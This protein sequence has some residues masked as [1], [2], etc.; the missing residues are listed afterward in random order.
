M[1]TRSF[2]AGVAFIAAFIAFSAPALAD[3][4]PFAPRF[5][6]NETGNIAMAANSL[7]TCTTDTDC[8]AARNGPS[9]NTTANDELNNNN[10]T[11][12]YI[13]VDSDSSTFS[14]SSANLN[15]PNGSSVLWAGLYW[16]GDWS[17][18]GGTAP[19]NVN[20]RNKMKLKL[21]GAGSYTNVTAS[22]VDESALNIGR[23]QAFADVT[24]LVTSGGAGSYFGANVQAG[25]SSDHYAGW[26]MVVAYKDTTQPARN[27]TV[28][29][30]LKTIRPSDPPTTIT[31]SGFLTPPS[32]AVNSNVGFITW[33]GDLG[34]VGDTAS[35]NGTTLSD[36]TNPATNFFNGTIESNTRN[37]SYVNNFGFDADI[38]QTTNVLPNSSTS[39]T[40]RLTT[41]GDQYLPGALFFAT[42][43]Y[44]PSIAQSKTVTDLNGGETLPGDVLEYTVTNTNSNASGTDAAT[45]F[46][47]RD[48][49]P[50]DT[51]YVPGSLK[52]DGAA[53]TD[54]A[55]DDTANYD[56][57]LKRIE[58]RLGTGA[59]A[60][61]GGR[62]APGATSQVKFRVTV[63]SPLPDDRKIENTATASFFSETTNTPLTATSSAD[64]TVGAPDLAIEKRR[65]SGA[66]V[67]GQD[68]DYELDVENVGDASSL[69]TVTVTD[70]L[71][72]GLT[73]KSV[74]GTGWTC[75]TTLPRDISCTRSSALAPG[76]SYPVISLKA[77]TDSGLDGAVTNTATVSGGS[78]VN[79]A[80]NSGSNT[81]ASSRTADVA[82]TKSASPT[83]INVGEQSTFTIQVRNNGPSTAT[84]VGLDDPIPAGLQQVGNANP[85]Q[86]TCQAGVVTCNLGNI[87]PG[88][89]V[90]VTVTV[91]ATSAAAGK[92]IKN[93]A[94]A[95]STGAT[96]PTP[97]NNS[98]EATVTVRPVD[99]RVV[100]TLSP[101]PPV[102]GQPIVYTIVATNDGPSPA[103]GVT[104]RDA[105]PTKMQNPL[106]MDDG[107]AT[108]TIVSGELNC[109][110]ASLPAGQSRTIKVM[111]TLAGDATSISN[112]ASITGAEIDSNPSNNTSTVAAD[113]SPRADLSVLKTASP[114]TASPGDEVVY[115]L[116]ARNDGPSTAIHARITDQLPDGV[117]FVSSPDCTAVSGNV[118][119]QLGDIPAGQQR[120]A[121]L[122]I[123]IDSDAPS[124]VT[125]TATI[126]SDVDDPDESDNESSSTVSVAGGADI[127]IEKQADVSS[128]APG[129]TITY[130]LTARNQGPSTSKDVS[131][132]DTIP[133]GLEFISS[134]PGSPTCTQAAGT[135]N[136]ALGDIPSGG[137]RTVTVRAK[138]LPVAQPTDHG[139][140]LRV[141]RVQRDLTLD[142]GETD[143][144][145]VPCPSGM[146]ATD[147][148]V[149][150]LDN[151]G[152]F[153]TEIE[154][155]A[156][157]QDGDG[158]SVK[159][160][161]SSAQDNMQT[162]VS[163]VCLAYRTLADGNPSHDHQLLVSAPHSRTEA[164]GA[165]THTY[166]LECGPGQVA[167][168]PSFAFTGSEVR[169]RGSH[170]NG[171]GWRF[172][173]D[174]SG[175]A[176]ADLAI[177][178]LDERTGET[179]GHGHGL[180]LA[181]HDRTVTVGAGQHVTARIE[182]GQDGK[183]IV[184]SY[185]LDPGLV[186][187]G[188]EPQ[189]VNRDF[190][191]ANPTDS[192]L[193]ARLGLL[194]LGDRTIDQPPVS[195]YVN[196]ASVSAATP[197]TDSGDTVDSATVIRS[198]A[199]SGSG[200]Q[201]AAA[202][203]T[204]AQPAAEA[205]A[206][207]STEPAPE[208]PAEEEP[209]EPEAEMPDA[210]G[211]ASLGK[212]T[213]SIP[214]SCKATCAGTATVFAPKAIKVGKSSFAK[215][216]VIG[217]VDYELD[218]GRASIQ[219]KLGKKL[220][221]A[222][223]K[224]KVRS[225]NVE[226]SSPGADTVS[227]K[228]QIRAD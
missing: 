26:S 75:S 57:S 74:S 46:V 77:G 193:D 112:T 56:G 190:R 196:T 79:F 121:T 105:L 187:L 95:S 153:E 110:I 175:G 67:A 152:N 214:V 222:L 225:L 73:V 9:T 32:G 71:P 17:G 174:S 98:G 200:G 91:K 35:L 29:D 208:P 129:D 167:I 43:L 139:H 199:P 97:G 168:A 101:N 68:V 2:A 51:T 124:T 150:I 176:T 179:N 158:Y 219:L 90:T 61:A 198:G 211:A 140:Q 37:P 13:D 24:N 143:S 123:K 84:S 218:A 44:A 28:F 189:P 47:L 60:S 195:Q 36:S 81:T 38:F 203:D 178:C 59:N 34:L 49:I 111:G 86:G 108:C 127:S 104:V 1:L 126:D 160:T 3:D 93:V 6:V 155:D 117:T 210:G 191:L 54:A 70:T 4:R 166:D 177:R 133:A 107:G 216:E 106:V 94:T 100:K 12:S 131:V 10:Y 113:V 130:T 78:D 53:R 137:T 62:L 11:M 103:S 102:A 162:R 224:A 109:A 186:S 221:E 206:P 120:T 134:T 164:L 83:T 31:V 19:V 146:F 188:N 128:A 212:T 169:V 163:V 52:I 14:S 7:M 22:V 159:A 156:V 50:N 58:A 80:N 65:T 27:L 119:C 215:G 149:L 226:L 48:P 170:R 55:G 151:A 142:R 228:V 72:A 99:L 194:C 89:T 16:G 144:V 87:A 154:P 118:I 135:V 33:E 20:D 209:A 125:N 171:T 96:D 8:T 18:S 92:T 205:V 25:R 147:A 45:G 172:V 115:T 185:D 220:A 182:C 116:T 5:S 202:P 82:V 197:D 213:L 184:A 223:R 21:P 76:A 64:K 148:S 23:Y 161:N 145:G 63:G 204:S 122:R 132:S 15:L 201:G 66:I 39:A 114:T 42:D 40:L 138:V 136:C 181:Q 85:S 69:G 183:G 173:L 88:A 192:A 217:E 30:G 141:E 157:E 180:A 41:N 227:V 165:G 207:A